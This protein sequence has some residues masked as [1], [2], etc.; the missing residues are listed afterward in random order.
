MELI[1]G[2]IVLIA[3]IVFTVALK[4]KHDG[5]SEEPLTVGQKILVWVLCLLNPVVAGAIMYYGWRKSLPAKAKT[6]NH[7]SLIAFLGS[8]AIPLE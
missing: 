1:I 6:A 4:R 8:Y 2:L 7:I 5:V 3:T